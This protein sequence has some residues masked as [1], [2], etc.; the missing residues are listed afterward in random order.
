MIFNIDLRH[1]DSIALKDD[2]GFV[3]TYGELA[4]V[5]QG[6]QGILSERSLV[7]I[8]ARNNA[9]T[10][11]F[12][13]SCLEKGWVPLVVN[14]NTDELLVN[15][16][17]SKYKPNA[18]F[19][20]N[21]EKYSLNLDCFQKKKWFDSS[22]LILN[23]VNHELNSDLS[24]LLPTSG[25]TGSPKLVRHS[26]D[27]LRIS[28][29]S[30]SEFFKFTPNDV[31]LASL[32]IYYTM[33]LSVVTS[34]LA[35]GAQV[36]LSNY[37]ITDREFWNVLKSEEISVFTGVPYSFDV[38]FKMRF[39]RM[40][41]PSLRIIS[42]G[43]G[44]LSDVV[45]EKLVNYSEQNNLKFI[46]TYGQ[47]EGTARMAFLDSEFTSAK[48]GS[49][50][51]AIPN[52]SFE[53]WDEHDRPIEEMVATGELIYKG[54]NVTLGYAENI[55]DLKKGDERFGILKTGDIVRRD[56]D[57]FYYILGR[58]NRFLKIFG[59]RISLDEVELL[60][61]NN[62]QIDCYCSGSDELLEIYVNRE[63]LLEEIKAWLVKKIQLFHNVVQVNYIVEIPRN[64]VGKVIFKS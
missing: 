64:N 53:I 16:Y 22:I 19:S 6:S 36:R 41:I 17:I 20:I 44:K 55:N 32:P 8:L 51:K 5:I 46:P 18:I 49:I 45:W 24:L 29:E 59:L 58:S 12:I 28:A 31:G 60:V 39:E 27:N 38:L 4:R 62:F 26:Y 40:K 33:G 35:A 2:N 47:T 48:K 15:E 25:S 63:D 9:S 56:I 57:G 13:L 43:G 10:I 11:S 14:S 30:V 37:S 7:L 34:L 42:Q 1:S 23:Q 50:G 52:G 3:L 54:G 21:V 61:K